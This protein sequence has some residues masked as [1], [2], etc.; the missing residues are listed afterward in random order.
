MHEQIEGYAECELTF[1]HKRVP[2]APSNGGVTLQ[3]GIAR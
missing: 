3:I 2:A 1:A